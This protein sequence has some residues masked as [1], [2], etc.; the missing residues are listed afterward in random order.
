MYIDSWYRDISPICRE[1]GFCS[2]RRGCSRNITANRF[3]ACPW[4][5]G[6]SFIF[7]VFVSH[8]CIA[9]TWTCVSFGCESLCV[10]W[11]TQKGR[12]T[13][14]LLCCKGN[15]RGNVVHGDQ[16]AMVK[17]KHKPVTCSTSQTA[18]QGKDKSFSREIQNYQANCLNRQHGNKW[19]RWLVPEPGKSGTLGKKIINPLCNSQISALTVSFQK[20]SSEATVDMA[21]KAPKLGRGFGKRH[22]VKMLKYNSNVNHTIIEC[23]F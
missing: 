1:V 20:K 3:R 9:L 16:R 7:C 8:L 5:Q 17:I 2:L 21:A 23:R 11:G 22:Y 18:V 14:T 13:W 10:I 12:L 4:P 6:K 19:S 15:L